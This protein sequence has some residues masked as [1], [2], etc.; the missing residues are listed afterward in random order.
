MATQIL[1]S[2]RKIATDTKTN[3]LQS[4]YIRLNALFLCTR[5]GMMSTRG[6]TLCNLLQQGEPAGTFW[7]CESCYLPWL[8]VVSTDLF[9]PGR[10]YGSGA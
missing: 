10:G 3:V 7:L 6:L 5:R 9:Q 4:I 2:C 8:S 1:V